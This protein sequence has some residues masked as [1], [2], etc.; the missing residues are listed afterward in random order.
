MRL[1]FLSI[2]TSI[3]CV[4]S[5]GLVLSWIAASFQV[6]LEVLQSYFLLDEHIQY[7]LP[8]IFGLTRLIT[9]FHCYS[10]IILLPLPPI[11]YLRWGIHSFCSLNV[12]LFIT[13]S[14]F[15]PALVKN[16]FASFVVSH[17][18]CS[19]TINCELFVR[20]NH[21]FLLLRFPAENCYFC[22]LC[23]L[24]P[25]DENPRKP[26]WFMILFGLIVI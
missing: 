2:I 9:S 1:A 8:V 13:N 23:F 19:L 15:L 4:L 12:L 26:Y 21:L 14:S 5:K 3:Y 18:L 24:L 10:S 6:F 16:F 17:I 22:E 25:N 20:V 7:I 11:F